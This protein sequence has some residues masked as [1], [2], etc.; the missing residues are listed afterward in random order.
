MPR[1][2][3]VHEFW[4]ATGLLH[5]ARS[6][7]PIQAMSKIRMISAVSSAWN[8]SNPDPEPNTVIL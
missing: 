3:I 7:G 6:Y 5:P 2:A 8:V 1:S 4:H